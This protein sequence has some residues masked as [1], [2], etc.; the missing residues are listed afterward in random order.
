MPIIEFFG[1][2]KTNWEVEECGVWFDFFR[3]ISRMLGTVQIH[4]EYHEKH[5]INCTGLFHLPLLIK[6][7]AFCSRFIFGNCFKTKK[8]HFPKSRSEVYSIESIFMWSSWVFCRF[9][10]I[11][12]EHKK[13]NFVKIIWRNFNGTSLFQLFEK[14]D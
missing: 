6:N 12:L 1:S 8:I 2:E 13:F 7:S 14:I 9:F 10:W 5:L 11:C 4:S 3:P